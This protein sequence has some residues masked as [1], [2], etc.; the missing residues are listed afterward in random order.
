MT[1]LK[2][3]VSGIDFENPVLLASGILDETGASMARVASLGAGGVV[4]KSIGLEPRSGHPNPCIVESQHGLINAMGLPNP[5]MEDYSE[6]IS[7]ALDAGVPVMASIFADKPEDFSRLAKMAKDAGAHA[8]ELNLSCPHAKGLGLEIGQDPRLAGMIVQSVKGAG[9]PVFPK[10]SPHVNN[11]EEMARTF[12]DAGAD[13]IV[14]INTL[15]A[16]AIDVDLRAPI[17]G[18]IRGGLS[19]PSVKPVGVRMIYDLHR[20]TKLPLI[21]VGGISC[22][23]DA[24]EYIMAGA[25]LVQVGTTAWQRGPG[26]CGEIACELGKEL[27]RLGYSSVQDA[28]GAAHWLED[29]R[30]QG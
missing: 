19:G 17:L 13:G 14:A 15:R 1:S 21:G 11:L 18:N 2:A 4:T 8:L 23:R 10:I 27:E 3:S 6:E 26:A 20:L 12:E 9:L 24:L 7:E 29:E 30:G 5:G 25:S 22:G 28:V 16:L